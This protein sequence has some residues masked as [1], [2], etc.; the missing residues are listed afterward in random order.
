MQGG[1][2]VSG[3]TGH[4][5]TSTVTR[6]QLLSSPAE[7]IEVQPVFVVDGMIQPMPVPETP[8]SRP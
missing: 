3:L 2:D 5:G 8:N 7:H 4:L 6:V 1:A